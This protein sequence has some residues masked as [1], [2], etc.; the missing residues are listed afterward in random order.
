MEHQWNEI[1]RGKPTTGEKPVPVSLCP[2]QISNGLDLGSISGLRG[3]RPATNRLSHG[4]AIC[5]N[6]YLSRNMNHDFVYQQ[7]LRIIVVTNGRE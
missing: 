7:T 3:E 5:N 1:D 2:P 6:I 4:T